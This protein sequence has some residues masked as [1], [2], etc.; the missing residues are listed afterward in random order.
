MLYSF[1]FVLTRG[2]S[3]MRYMKFELRFSL[4]RKT[5]DGRQQVL[6]KLN[7]H[8]CSNINMALVDQLWVTIHPL[9]AD[10]SPQIC[11]ETNFADQHWYVLRVQWNKTHLVD[12]LNLPE[13]Q[14]V[15]PVHL[16]HVALTM[17]LRQ[18]D[19]VREV[20]GRKRAGRWEERKESSSVASELCDN[21]AQI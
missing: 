4:C 9:H 17:G 8:S 13:G 3:T 11:W 10:F 15:Q 1:S 5:G 16:H 7:L 12:H 2:N 6:I 18:L 19:G 20:G 21:H 14:T